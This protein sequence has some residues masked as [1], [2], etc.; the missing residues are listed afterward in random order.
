MYVLGHVHICQKHSL[1][2][3][4]YVCSLDTGLALL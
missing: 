1:I 4:V 2:D 3:C